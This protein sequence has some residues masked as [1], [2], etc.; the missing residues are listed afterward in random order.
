MLIPDGDP[1]DPGAALRGT[2]RR[3]YRRLPERRVGARA[4]GTH[5]RLAGAG[6]QAH[7]H[8]ADHGLRGVLRRDADPGWPR[9]AKKY[10][11]VACNQ[12]YTWYHLGD[13]TLATFKDFGL[14]DL[15][16]VLVHD[17]YRNYDSTVFGGLVHQLCTAHILRD[18]ADAAEYRPAVDATRSRPHLTGFCP[19]CGHPGSACPSGHHA[20]SSRRRQRRGRRVG[21]RGP[22]R[23]A[24]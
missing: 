9:R 5:S 12:R 15:S 23:R 20:M 3:A 10:L 16:G 18:L 4:A 14:G 13:R 7:P 2:G 21:A 11:L 8:A 19:L 1:R 24:S 6:R 22:S 17:R